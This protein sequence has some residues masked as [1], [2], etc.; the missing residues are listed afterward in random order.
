MTEQPRRSSR[1]STKKSLSIYN[2]GD[3]VEITRNGVVTEG[4]LAYNL[5]EGPSANPRW[6]VKFDLEPWKDEELYER[7]FGTL[8]KKAGN[9]SDR[10]SPTDYPNKQSKRSSSSS[11]DDSSSKKRKSVTF[12]EDSPVASDSSSVAA[13]PG[14][15]RAAKK[16]RARQERITRRQAKI[17]LEDV[18]PKRQRDKSQNSNNK[19]SLQDDPNEEVIEVKMLTGTLYLY[20]GLNRRAEFVRKC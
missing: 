14:D 6:L 20:R 15:G 11:D 3:I 12:S 18:P 17:E 8:L 5:T 1:K 2:V 16:A 4:R 7:S 19:H 10:A 13:A 9:E